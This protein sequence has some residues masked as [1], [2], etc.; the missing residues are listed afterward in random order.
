LT[1]GSR[2]GLLAPLLLV[3]LL[4]PGSRFGL[5]APLLL[6]RLLTPLRLLW[7]SGLRRLLPP[8]GGFRLLTP[9]LLRGLPPL[10]LLRR[11]G[12]RRLL[13]PPGGFRLLTPS[14]LRG[15]PPLR[16]LGLSGLRRLLPPLRRLASS[17]PWISDWLS[18]RLDQR[19]VLGHGL[20][21]LC[22]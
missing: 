11:S 4:T 21:V 19:G 13:P 12:L 16:L 2:F 7:L 22:P 3:R 6:V 9:S 5:L 1:P 14:L 18:L 8:P 20:S 10:R 15:L 17:R